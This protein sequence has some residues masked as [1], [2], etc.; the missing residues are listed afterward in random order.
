LEEIKKYSEIPVH[1]SVFYSDFCFDF[2]LFDEFWAFF[3]MVFPTCLQDWDWNTS[4][5]IDHCHQFGFLEKTC[6]FSVF[7]MSSNVDY[8]FAYWENFD[9]S[10]EMA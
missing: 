2:A 1:N 7:A 9:G 4:D 3:P 8:R 10:A 5:V 6:I